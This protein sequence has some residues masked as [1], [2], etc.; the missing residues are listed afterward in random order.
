MAH[1]SSEAWL[2]LVRDVLPTGQAGPM[3]EH[4]EQGCRECAGQRDS[5][6]Q[7]G[8]LVR[9]D[10]SFE[11]PQDAVRIVK[12]WSW[13]PGEVSRPALLVF[14]SMRPGLVQGIRS[15]TTGAHQLLYRA[16][17]VCIDL[18]IEPVLNSDEVYVIGQLMDAEHPSESV[19]AVHVSLMS[20]KQ[21]MNQTDT[22]ESGEFQMAIAPA[23]DLDL[24]IKQ[25]LGEHIRI[26]LKLVTEQP[27]R[28][29]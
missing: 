17:S 4:L 25:G 13:Q 11:P 8:G 21:L 26:P 12:S 24:C 23:A 6:E 10:P 7:V 22:N 5:W 20:G 3:Q 2:D 29:H 9:R 16:G 19:G 18:R 14:D 1:F 27:K 15:T 28:R